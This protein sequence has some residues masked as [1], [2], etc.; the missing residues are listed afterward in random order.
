VSRIFFDWV[1]RRVKMTTCRL[2]RNLWLVVSLA[3]GLLNGCG[4]VIV[5]VSAAEVKSVASVFPDEPAAHAIYNQMIEAMRKADSLSYV[6]HYKRETRGMVVAD[7]TYR[8]WLRKPTYFR[9]ETES[10]S[11]GKGGI[12]VGDGSTVWI[13]WPEGRPQFQQE[14]PKDYQATQLKSYMKKPYQA[15]GHAIAYEVVFAGAGIGMSVPILDPGTFHG[16]S[17]TLQP[18]LDGV[19]S[20]GTGKVGT[21][22]CDKIEV[23]FMKGQRTWH[24]SLAKKDH[25]PRNLKQ[26]VRLGH[27]IVTHE[28][29]SLVTQDAD[30]PQTMFAWKPPEGWKEW[31]LPN[32]AERLLE[33]GTEAPDFELASADGGRVRLSGYRGQVVWLNGWRAGCPGCRMEMVDLQEVYMRWKDKGLVILGFNCADDKKVGLEFLR[34]NGAT[35]PTI[36]DSSESAEEVYLKGYRGS[37]FPLNYVIDREGKIVD[38]WYGYERGY[39]RA[40]AALAKMGIKD[41]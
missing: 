32:L 1:Y 25:L 10:L 13:Y 4:F 2:F 14:E 3:M 7:C 8:V 33:P 31:R 12:L 41:Q 18:Y 36:L 27:D 15:G 6:G 22:D 9:V 30:I 20:T 16:Y 37:G 39:P 5:P 11:Q 23:S 38:A 28:Q 26:I 17:D 29:W 19:R 35:F 34:E 40:K 24:L 21:E